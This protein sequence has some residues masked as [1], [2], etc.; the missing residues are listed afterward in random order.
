L[1]PTLAKTQLLN[2]S[3]HPPIILIFFAFIVLLHS[4]WEELISR[5]ISLGDLF[6]LGSGSGTVGVRCQH[7]LQ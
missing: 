5:V 3:Q 7:H 4:R 1:C 6:L 2:F